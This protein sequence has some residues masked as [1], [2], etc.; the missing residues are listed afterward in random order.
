MPAIEQI[1]TV[2]D[3]YATPVFELTYAIGHV[4]RLA[5]EEVMNSLDLR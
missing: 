5:R 1:E 3:H 4:S 2:E